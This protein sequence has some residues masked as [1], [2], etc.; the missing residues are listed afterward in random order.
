MPSI[1]L[2]QKERDHIRSLF[3]RELK[4]AH[5]YIRKLKAI[6]RKLDSIETPNII[7]PVIIKEEQ[8][9]GKTRKPA[10]F[11]KQKVIFS[12]ND[13]QELHSTVRPDNTIADTAP[14]GKASSQYKRP[15]KRKKSNYRPQGVFLEKLSK[16][17][18]KPSSDDPGIPYGS[19]KRQF[20]P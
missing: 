4:D 9:Q 11:E 6:L 7:K 10:S 15:R 8:A 14:V 12:E 16:P 13:N 3:E 1:K 20:T 18:P 2:T 5:A 19:V 17:L